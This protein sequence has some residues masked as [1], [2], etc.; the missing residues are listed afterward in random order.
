MLLV[1][2]HGLLIIMV[3]LCELVS[4]PN[5]WSLSFEDHLMMECGGF[6]HRFWNQIR[7]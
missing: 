4:I 7:T 6:H 5:Y 2:I 1:M 3:F